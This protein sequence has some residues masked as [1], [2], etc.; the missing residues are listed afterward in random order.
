MKVFQRYRLASAHHTGNVYNV[1]RGL[2]SIRRFADP[3]YAAYAQ[4]YEQDSSMLRRQTQTIHNG[5]S[6]SI[7]TPVYNPPPHVL[8]QLIASVRAQTYPCWQW[9]IADASTD[10]HVARTLQQAARQE[11]RI[12]YRQ[13]SYNAGI[14]ANTQAAVQDAN[15]DYLVLLDHDDCLRADALFCVAQ[16]AQQTPLPDLLYS[17]EDKLPME[18]AV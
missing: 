9:C 8:W 7:I 1:L 16:A 15:G 5:P 18:D 4:R 6:F 14:S 3:F 10:A 12:H 17:D 13:L 2:R 11:P